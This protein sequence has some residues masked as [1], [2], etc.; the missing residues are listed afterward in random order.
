MQSI[1]AK[2]Y[3]YPLVEAKKVYS[4]M[5]KVRPRLYPKMISNSFL[6]IE[7]KKEDRQIQRPCHSWF[8]Y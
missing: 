5:S 4:I 8:I 6:Y 1:L 7:A 2:E 3:K